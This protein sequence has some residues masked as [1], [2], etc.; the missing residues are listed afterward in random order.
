MLLSWAAGGTPRA[1]EKTFNLGTIQGVSSPS[2]AGPPRQW[3]AGPPDQEIAMDAGYTLPPGTTED[4]HTFTLSTGSSMPRWVARVDLLPGNRSMVRAASIAVENGP[5][6][7]LWVPGH[8]AVAAP[9]GTAFFIPAHARLTLRM[10]YK[11]NWQDEQEAKSDRSTIGLY[12]TEAPLS[13]KS[14]QSLTIV[15]PATATTAT[16]PVIFEQIVT[17]AARVVAFTPSMDR[18]YESIIIDAVAAGGRRQT[19]LKLRATQP[20]WYRRYWLQEPI[21]LVSGTTIKVTAS[22]SPPD[23]LA[24]PPAK[25]YPLGIGVEYVPL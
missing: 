24:P 22:P 11:K 15:P 3:S 6:L 5:L 13:A 19:L 12:F 18:P 10:H 1:D 16:D 4:D 17:S 21:E 2:Y 25:R 14:I 9:S 7:A 8:Q 23:E 20:Q